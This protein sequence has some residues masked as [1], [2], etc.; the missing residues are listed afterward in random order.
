MKIS[1]VIPTH[2]RADTIMR[3]INS[4]LTQTYPVHELIIV[5][6]CST[7]NTKGIL[8]SINDDRV[9]FIELE[10]QSGGAHARNVGINAAQGDYIALLDSDDYWLP[11]KIKHQVEMIEKSGHFS[12]VVVYNSVQI[13]ELGGSSISPEYPWPTDTPLDLYLS[14]HKQHMQTSGLLIDSATLKKVLFDT[15]L[16]I[17]QDIDLALRLRDF[18]CTF[19][20]CREPTVVFDNTRI[21][22]RVSTNRNAER[23]IAFLSKW[24]SKLD[25]RTIAFYQINK[26]L[27]VTLLQNPKTAIRTAAH[28]LAPNPRLTITLIGK[29]IEYHAPERLYLHL[30]ST[31]RHISRALR[32]TRYR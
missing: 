24:G 25:P 10:T 29:L 12:P 11:N 30:R 7:D 32:R 21:T 5:D 8:N 23:T 1:T 17:H 6:D 28:Y 13:T 2:N 16:R 20:F 14:S 19:I 22:G 18:G 27:P 26:V 3:A 31:V 9:R 15:N 4:V